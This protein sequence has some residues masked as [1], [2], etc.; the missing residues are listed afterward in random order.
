MHLLVISV[1]MISVKFTASCFDER[2]C[3]LGNIS[4][5][6]SGYII[7]KRKESNATPRAVAILFIVFGAENYSL[8]PKRHSTAAR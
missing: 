2:L 8:S 7:R 6:A 3:K 5:A 1:I 4:S